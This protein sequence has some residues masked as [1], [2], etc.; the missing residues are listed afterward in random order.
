[1]H[2]GSVRLM[3]GRSW[4]ERNCERGAT[5][6]KKRQ[7]ATAH[8]MYWQ[9]DDGGHDGPGADDSRRRLDRASTSE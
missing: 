4:S 8:W 7:S 6:A 5:R 1:M 2:F 3:L 9:A